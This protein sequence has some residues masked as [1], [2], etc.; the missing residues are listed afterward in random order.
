MN[1]FLCSTIF[2]S[3]IMIAMGC[4]SQSV[5]HVHD[6]VKISGRLLYSPDGS[7]LWG[8]VI[9]RASDGNAFMTDDSGNFVIEAQ[10]G[11]S[12]HF[13][14]VGT[15]GKTIPVAAEDSTMTVLLDPYVPGHDEYVVRQESLYPEMEVS[16]KTYVHDKDA[17]IGVA[18]IINGKDT[19]SVKGKRDF[20]MLSVYKFPQALAVADY[21]HKHNI[22]L[23]DTIR[24]SADDLNPD[25]WSPMR[26]KYGRKDISLPLSEIL[27][28]SVQQSDNN[29]CDVLFRLIGGPQVADSLMKCFGYD[30]IHILN[31]EDEMHRDPYLCYANRATPLQM[32]ALFDRFYRQEMR[33]DTRIL[34]AV[35]AMMMQCATGNNRLPQPLMPTNAMIGHKTG[36]GGVNSQGRI[37]GVND[38]GYVF[39]PNKQGYAIAVF[40]A[41]SGYS[42]QETEKMIADISEIV[43]KSLMM[44]EAVMGEYE[45]SNDGSTLTIYKKENG[46]IGV[47]IGL[48]RLSTIDDGLGTLSDCGLDFSATDAAGNPI[49]GEIVVEGNRAILTFTQSTWEYLPNG[50]TYTFQRK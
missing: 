17:R 40:I 25:T 18:V 10:P 26:D 42:M 33:H 11:D 29:A 24:I 38:A 8:G 48:M 45:D 13:S 3:L 49:Y 12:L 32:A 47:E 41:D 6:R 44:Q 43:F 9:N 20:P 36:T 4:K 5:R 15:I 31:T 50:T 16:L 14:F 2:L 23:N 35:G 39:L 7:P 1:K 30:E 27:A 19:V 21:C 37:S 22:S 46:R 34:E 28:Y